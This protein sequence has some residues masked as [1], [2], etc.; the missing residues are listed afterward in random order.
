MGKK[1]NK[2]KKMTLVCSYCYTIHTQRG[3]KKC[4]NCGKPHHSSRG[5]IYRAS[6][7]FGKKHIKNGEFKYKGKERVK[8]EDRK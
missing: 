8:G 6:V 3:M 7:E 2:K 4:P 5:Q 1:K